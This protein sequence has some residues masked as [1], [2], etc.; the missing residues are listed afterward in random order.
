MNEIIITGRLTKDPELRTTQTGLSVTS[1][2]VAVDKRTANNEKAVDYFDC[3]AYRRTAETI[4]RYF[5][6]G[7]PIL[8]EGSMHMRDWT[9][10]SGQK[11][12]SWELTVDNFEFMGGD[13]KP[14]AAAPVNAGVTQAELD[15][16]MTELPGDDELPFDI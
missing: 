5:M 10:K 12:R 7:K 6:K 8:I 15:S 14:E 1:F 3:V 9:D 16:L 4:C 13:K 2:S 11:R